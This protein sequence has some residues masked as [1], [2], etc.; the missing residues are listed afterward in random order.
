MYAEGF[1]DIARRFNNMQ[2]GHQQSLES[3]QMFLVSSIIGGWEYPVSLSMFGLLWLKARFDWAEGYA[4]AA[5][6]RYD[7][8]LAIW[9]WF[10][11]LAPLIATGIMGVKTLMA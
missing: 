5:K 4:Q 6:N 1:S 7:K 10:G 8:P 9:V 11:L 2:R 3:F